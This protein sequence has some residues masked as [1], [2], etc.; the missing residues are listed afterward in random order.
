MKKNQQIISL[1]QQAQLKRLEA[2]DICYSQ[3]IVDVEI[4]QLKR[5]FSFRV[6]IENR[7]HGL[8]NSL[9]TYGF[10]GG[11]F[12]NE[13]NLGV[14]DGW[15]RLELWEQMGNT[16]IPCY[17][18]CCSEHQQ[19]ELHLSLNQQSADFDLSKFGLAFEK[20]DLKDFGFTEAELNDCRGMMENV[21]RDSEDSLES[22]PQRIKRPVIPV[23]QIT[24]SRIDNLKKVLKMTSRNDVLTYLLDAHENN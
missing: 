21:E 18:L 6:P 23:T 7:L 14:I 13:S 4:A 20:F 22:A 24:I 2:E 19:K 10:L 3:E 5:L 15:H 11:I 17:F 1:V 8:I 9:S 16:T 12:V